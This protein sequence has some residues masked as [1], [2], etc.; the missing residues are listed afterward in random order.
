MIEELRSR[1]SP[2]SVFWFRWFTDGEPDYY[3][4]LSLG[5]FRKY[6]QIVSSCVFNDVCK[7]HTDIDERYDINRTLVDLLSRNF[8]KKNQSCTFPLCHFH[9]LDFSIHV[10]QKMWCDLFSPNL[11]LLTF[12]VNL[13]HYTTRQNLNIDCIVLNCPIG[14]VNRH[15]DWLKSYTNYMLQQQSAYMRVLYGIS[16]HEGQE[17]YFYKL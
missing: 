6:L 17:N 3:H 12:H 15:H 2:L 13:Y 4:S 5:T 8:I 11:L 7:L 9:I 16:Q 1:K 10:C 14:R